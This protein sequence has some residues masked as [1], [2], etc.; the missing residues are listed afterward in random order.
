MTDPFVRRRDA[1]QK[2]LDTWSKRPMRLGTSD[3][4]RMAVSHL[5]LLG[6]KV[7]LPPSGSYRTVRGALKELKARGH[8]TLAEA[9]DGLGLERIAPAAAIVGDL[10]MLPSDT[11]LGG[12]AVVVGNGRAVAYHEDAIGACVIQPH[13]FDVAWRVTP[14]NG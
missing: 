12:L 5:R 7:K 6:Y 3:C 2:T 13:D 11:C 8:A 9:I 14:R 4:L 1:A 10:M